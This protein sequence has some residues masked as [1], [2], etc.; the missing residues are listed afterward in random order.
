[1]ELVSIISTL[2]LIILESIE[3]IGWLF[4]PLN[5]VYNGDIV[6]F[7]PILIISFGVLS[8]LIPIAI[9]KWAIS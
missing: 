3:N 1:M 6:S 4:A 9:I 2:K 8:F 5:I 7:S